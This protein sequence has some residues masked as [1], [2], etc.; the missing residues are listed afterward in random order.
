LPVQT[1]ANAM[2]LSNKLPIS[3][4]RACTYTSC[5]FYPNENLL[6]HWVKDTD[7]KKEKTLQ[8]YLCQ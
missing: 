5:S 2:N 1:Q 4:A 6:K 7:R 8:K 3:E